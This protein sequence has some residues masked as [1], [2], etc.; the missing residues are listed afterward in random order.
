M[1]VFGLSQNGKHITSDWIGRREKIQILIKAS[2]IIHSIF[3]L[4]NY[5]M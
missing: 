5:E 4:H 2:I 1:F 3:S